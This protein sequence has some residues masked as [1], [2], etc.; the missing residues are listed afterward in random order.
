MC[1]CARVC[2]SY[3][4]EE[5]NLYPS[6]PDPENKKG[7][8]FAKQMSFFVFKMGGYFVF[9]FLFFAFSVGPVSRKW[10]VDVVTHG[11]KKRRERESNRRRNYGWID[12]SDCRATQKKIFFFKK[13]KKK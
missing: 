8:I 2:N 13:S 3:V 7:P 5:N 10:T 11:K 6:K 4:K 12:E 1:V 9:L